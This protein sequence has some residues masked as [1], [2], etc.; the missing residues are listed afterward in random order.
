MITNEREYRIARAELRRFEEELSKPRL[1]VEQPGV[2]PAL[3]AATPAILNQQLEDLRAE[4]R[5]YEELRSGIHRSWEFSDL[6]SLP[7]VLIESRIARGLTQRELAD[8]LKLR[9]QAIQRYEDNRYAGASFERIV[10]VAGVLGLYV[11]VVVS[12]DPQVTSIAPTADIFTLSSL[13]VGWL[14]VSS[15][16]PSSPG[17]TG[18]WTGV[19]G[20]YQSLYQG[21]G[22]WPS[23]SVFNLPGGST[24]YPFTP[25]YGQPAGFGRI[26]SAG[27]LAPREMVVWPIEV[28]QELPDLQVAGSSAR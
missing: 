22:T 8:E 16:A 20:S 27:G 26:P 2:H 9:E 10:D 13:G 5:E 6:G 21:F 18:F 3:V 1:V 23:R 12:L 19:V 24:T 15:F 11:N 28:N 14:P 4:V 25:S 7:Q 17:L